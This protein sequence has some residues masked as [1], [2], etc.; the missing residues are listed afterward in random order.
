M[1]LQMHVDC[2]ATAATMVLDHFIMFYL[3]AWLQAVEALPCRGCRQWRHSNSWHASTGMAPIHHSRCLMLVVLLQLLGHLA[4]GIM[5]T[6]H[7][8][9]WHCRCCLEIFKPMF[10]HGLCGVAAGA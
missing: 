4:C 8:R 5:F 7:L 6:H 2:G 9:R 3:L 1:P 10:A